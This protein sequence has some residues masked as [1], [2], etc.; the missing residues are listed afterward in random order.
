MKA[1]EPYNRVT[2][3]DLLM[4]AYP[5]TKGTMRAA[6]VSTMPRVGDD[7]RVKNVCQKN[8]DLQG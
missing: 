3:A 1:K 2:E 5:R 4:L 6:R 8:P 7:C